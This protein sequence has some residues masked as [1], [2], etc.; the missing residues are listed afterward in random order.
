MGFGTVGLRGARL[1]GV[2]D[3]VM[4][5]VLHEGVESRFT[6]CEVIGVYYSVVTR[7]NNRQ[8]K[9]T[10]NQCGSCGVMWCSLSHEIQEV[11]GC[12]YE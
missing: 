6:G 9:P 3:R 7:T 1:R 2:V 5:G 10:L 4:R 12:C 11:T 8:E